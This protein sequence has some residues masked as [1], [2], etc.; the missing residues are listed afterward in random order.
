MEKINYRKV[1]GNP[2]YRANSRLLDLGLSSLGLILFSPLFLYL[3]IKIKLED[4]GPIFYSQT[5]LGQ[6]GRTFKIWKFRSMIEGADQLKQELMDKN[7]IAGAMFKIKDDPRVTKIGKMMRRRSLDELPQLVN[8]LRGEMALIGPRPPLPE[9]A[10]QYSAYDWQR[11]LVKPGCSG[12]WQV[13]CR[14]DGDF[15]QMVQLDIKY[16]NQRSLWLDLRLMVK[17]IGLIFK[18]TGM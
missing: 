6:G 9:E 11:L 7:E 16:I 17:T 5:R 1:R 2:V 14:N 18:P 8:V 3:A 10:R 4:G 13:E 12:L 15:D